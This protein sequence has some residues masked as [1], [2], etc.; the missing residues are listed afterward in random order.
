M[1]FIRVYADESGESHF[2]DQ[3]VEL[4]DAGPIGR[5]S[6]TIPARGVIFRKN[7]S[8]YDYDWHVAPQ[9]QFIVLLDGV[10]EIEVSDG[11]R[12]TFRAG[13]I[14]LMEDTMGRG[15]RTRH[16]EAQERRSLFILLDEENVE[17]KERRSEP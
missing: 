10:I 15:H 11:E 4:K 5:L 9:R 8:G 6:E 13:E 2:A 7:D 1:R 3:E 14:L 17:P 12:R 16:L